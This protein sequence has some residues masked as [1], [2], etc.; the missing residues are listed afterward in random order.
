MPTDIEHGD[1]LARLAARHQ[2]RLAESLVTLENRIV[3]LMANAPLQDGNLFDLEWAISAR[4]EIRQL[5]DAEYLSQIDSILREY[6]SVAADAQ[7]MLKTYGKFTEIDP[8]IITQLQ[9]LEF[10]GFADIGAEYT[11]AIAKE[12]YQNTLTGRSFA[13]S[14][15]TVKQVAGGEMARYA[16][17]QVH[18]SLMQF[19]AAINVSIGKEAG[20]KKWKYVGSLIETSRQFCKDH[21]GE[22]MD[23]EK[24]EQLWSTSWAGKAA[25]DPFIVRGG[26][27]CGHRFR[28]VFDEE[29]DTEEE[30]VEAVAE[31]EAAIPSGAPKLL[32]K[33]VALSQI[34]T[35]AS[36]ANKRVTEAS[37][38]TGYI[39]ESPTRFP[40]RFRPYGYKRGSD[41]DKLGNNQF[42]T[43]TDKGMSSETLSLLDSGLKEIEG[44]SKQFKTPPI[45]GVVPVGGKKT[46]MA[47]GD[48]MLSVNGSYWNPIAKQA[49]VPRDKLLENT[50][51]SRLELNKADE[52]YEKVQEEYQS[53]LDAF[54]LKFPDYRNDQSYRGSPEWGLLQQKNIQRTDA[55]EAADKARK[56]W[57]KDRKLSEVQPP[58]AYVRGG[59]ISDRPWSAKQY[60][61]DPA[62]KFRS[63]L[64]HEYGHTVHQEYWRQASAMGDYATPIEKYLRQLFYANGK[65]GAK[66]KDLFFPT[67]Y[68]ETNPEEWW[69]EN[70]SLYNMGR[71]D[72]VDTKLLAL[73]DEIVKS[74]GRIK[75][76]DG[77]NFETGDYA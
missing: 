62:D 6:P 14:V 70:F 1:N 54:I 65:K 64:F 34:S 66:S 63:T 53:A 19:D 47:M 2:E 75:V 43:I 67:R 11:D 24:I 33:K 27:N 40:V 59:D 49:Y 72:L 17:Q 36:K 4:N 29:A 41:V 76:F 15:N 28:P 38:P 51:A 25:G 21:E 61:S 60:H 8:K 58:S 73:M 18:D 56:K 57:D 55:K 16:K 52:Y 12:V 23:D 42:G 46:T 48:G 30:T 69:A 20:A 71:K 32:D 3:D 10:Q 26:Y 5:V 37:D 39:S 77:W 13:D 44:L 50:K 74:K 45:R 7:S 9:T 31:P 22:V 35:F 68:S